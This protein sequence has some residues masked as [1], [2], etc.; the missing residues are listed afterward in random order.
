MQHLSIFSFKEFII[1]CIII[2]LGSFC[3]TIIAFQIYNPLEQ[4]NG[5]EIEKNITRTYVN[6]YIKELPRLIKVHNNNIGYIGENYNDSIKRVKVLFLGSSTTQSLFI[7]YDYQWTTLA[8]NKS[9]IWSNNCG[10]GGSNVNEWIAELKKLHSIKPNFIIILFNP[11]TKELLNSF[12]NGT[13]NESFLKRTLNKISFYKYV[14]RPF[15]LSKLSRNID[16]GYK[17]VIWAEQIKPNPTN[18][19]ESIDLIFTKEKLDQLMF[20]IKE[21]GARPIIISQPTPYGKYINVHGNDISKVDNSISRD[22]FYFK[23]SNYLSSYCNQLNIPF[24]NGYQLDKNTDYFYDYSH[25]N[26]RGSS[27][28]SNLIKFKLDSLVTNNLNF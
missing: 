3:F 9:K 10:I 6:N 22:I 16:F 11:F 25:F 8:V 1:K 20:A 21:C 2:S 13:S 12:S 27:E 26:I 7:P 4:V 14:L 23:F 18:N 15:Y 17:K 5:N 24:I 28:F 19:F